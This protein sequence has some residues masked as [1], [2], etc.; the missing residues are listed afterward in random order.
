MFR[1]SS[2]HLRLPHAAYDSFH[3]LLEVHHPEKG[4]EPYALRERLRSTE[5]DTYGRPPLDPS[6]L[7]SAYR[8]GVTR[9]ACR[10][11]PKA[12]ARRVPPTSLFG[13]PL[14][15][16]IP[17]HPITR[18]SVQL[19]KRY[20]KRGPTVS[21]GRMIVIAARPLFTQR[22]AIQNGR[23]LTCGRVRRF[24]RPFAHIIFA[25]PVSVTWALANSHPHSCANGA[26]ADRI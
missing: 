25:T 16:D 9:R 4:G 20:A 24:G 19:R 18:N 22:S 2:S 26:C 23:Y 7:P 14:L 15:L 17:G 1:L 3:A 10:A 13:G 5:A 21:M 8:S 6:P 11:A 12:P